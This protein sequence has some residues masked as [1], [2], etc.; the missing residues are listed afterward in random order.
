MVFGT[1][2][3][4]WC[5]YLNLKDCKTQM[6]LFSVKCLCGC[7]YT[8]SLAFMHPTILRNLGEKLGY[9]IDVVGDRGLCS[10]KFARIS[11]L[12][13]LIIPLRKVCG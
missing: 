6:I 11:I 8:T 7:N 13:K 3:R 2:S 5:F 12:K 10:G 4:I 1:S 9:V